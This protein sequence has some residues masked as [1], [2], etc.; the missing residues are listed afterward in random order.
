MIAQDLLGK[1]RGLVNRYSSRSTKVYDAS[2]NNIT[3]ANIEV[4]GLIEATISQTTVTRAEQGIDSTYYAYYDVQEPMTLSVTLLPTAGCNEPLQY[5]AIR[6]KQ[7][8]GFCRINVEENG[9]LIDTFRAHLISLPEINM[10]MDGVVRTYVFGVISDSGVEYLVE[11]VETP[12]AEK[13][14]YTGN[15]TTYPLAEDEPITRRPM[16]NLSEINNEF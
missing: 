12:V 13:A 1:A 9:K 4:D 3:I 5:L 6:Q 15:A 11:T 10:R 16:P 14:P 2:K 8:K 7:L